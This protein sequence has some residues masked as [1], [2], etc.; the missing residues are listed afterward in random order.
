MTSR[1]VLVA[2]LAFALAGL[3]LSACSWTLFQRVPE[4]GYRPGERPRCS[5]SSLPIVDASLAGLFGTL[6]VPLTV[7]GA[8]WREGDDETPMYVDMGAPFL[9]VGIGLGVAAITHAISALSGRSY[10]D[11]CERAWDDYEQNSRPVA[12]GPR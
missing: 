9:A 4:D 6:A 1:K 10:A 11:D 3:L 12:G 5:N 8:T 2:G 7:G